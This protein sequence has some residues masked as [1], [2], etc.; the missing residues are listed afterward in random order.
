M[1]PNLPGS[2]VTPGQFRTSRSMVN[3][4]LSIVPP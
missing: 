3:M 4:Q 1:A 2:D